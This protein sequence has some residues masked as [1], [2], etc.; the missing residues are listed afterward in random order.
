MGAK[1]AAVRSSSVFTS[2]VNYEQFSLQMADTTCNGR[3]VVRAL[4]EDEQDAWLDLLAAAF[5]TKGV[6]RSFFAGWWYICTYNLPSSCLPLF[7]L[8]A[9]P[10][11]FIYLFL[12]IAACA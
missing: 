4:Q 2:V 10:L 6:P 8:L 11:L 7:H 1:F 5:A 3:Y 12:H 9:A